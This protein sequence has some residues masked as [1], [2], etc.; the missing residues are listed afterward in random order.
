MAMSVLSLPLL[1]LFLLFLVI[2]SGG[3][4]SFAHGQAP[5]QGS[6]CMAKPSSS[7]VELLENINYAC[8][9]ANCSAIQNDGPCYNPAS[10]LNH[11]S[12]AMNLY[13]QKAGRNFWNCDFKKSG[14]I[15]VTDPSYGDC[16]YQYSK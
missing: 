15:V 12:V 2:N 11:A 16:K 1:S 3:I 9:V 4:M 7:D 10:L 14:V 5:G 13:Y 6:W 8:G